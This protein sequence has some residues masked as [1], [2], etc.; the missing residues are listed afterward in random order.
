M[1]ARAKVSLL[2]YTQ[3]GRSGYALGN[4]EERHDLPMSSRNP[5]SLQRW[6]GSLEWETVQRAIFAT[7]QAKFHGKEILFVISSNG[8]SITEKLTWLE[9]FNVSL[10]PFD[11]DS[12][13]QNDSRRAA[14]EHEDAYLNSL[15]RRR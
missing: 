13:T 4:S 14:D 3:A 12:Q 15:I 6:R 11:G 1:A 5:S 2:L 7:H 9:D 10:N 8:W